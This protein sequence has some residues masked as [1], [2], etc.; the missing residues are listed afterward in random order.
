M[1]KVNGQI[2]VEQQPL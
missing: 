1:T 2:V